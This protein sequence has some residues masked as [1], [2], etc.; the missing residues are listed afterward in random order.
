MKPLT[1]R[2]FHDK[3]MPELTAALDL[4]VAYLKRKNTPDQAA[5]L[6]QHLTDLMSRIESA[7]SHLAQGI[8]GYLSWDVATGNAGQLIDEMARAFRAGSYHAPTIEDRLPKLKA[9]LTDQETVV[10]GVT[11]MLDDEEIGQERK[12]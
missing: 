10:D 1:Q 12:S 6:N 2:Y 3:V 7:S 4:N 11:S 8:T 5:L 9:L